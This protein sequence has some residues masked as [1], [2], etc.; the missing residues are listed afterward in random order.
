LQALALSHEDL[1]IAV[2]RL[3]SVLEGDVWRDPKFAKVSV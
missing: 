2:S 3:R 1:W